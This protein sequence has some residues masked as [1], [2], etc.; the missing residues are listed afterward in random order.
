MAGSQQGFAPDENYTRVFGPLYVQNSYVEKF[1]DILPDIPD[2]DFS[3]ISCQSAIAA[4]KGA[5]DML[6]DVLAMPNELMSMARDLI[7]KPFGDAE[8]IFDAAMSVINNIEAEIMSILS[9]PGAVIGKFQ[10]ALESMLDC[11]FLADSAIG[12]EAAGLLDIMNAGG[13]IMGML[14][15]FQSQLKAAAM[16]QMNAI[17]KIPLSKLDELQNMFQSA[18]DDLGVGDLINGINDLASCVAAVCSAGEAALEGVKGAADFLSGINGKFDEVTGKLTGAVVKAANDTEQAA[19]DF[20]NDL[21]FAK[22]KWS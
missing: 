13:S 22:I 6:E 3:E 4:L 12:K 16:D 17:K 11:P 8:K 21:A 18:L 19:I 7:N 20:A 15:G 1:K 14:G 5:S 10:A 2:I 9:G